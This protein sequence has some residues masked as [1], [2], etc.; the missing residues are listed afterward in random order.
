[1]AQLAINGASP[2]REAPYPAWTVT[3]EKDYER[4]SRTFD[5]RTWGPGGA[6]NRAFRAAFEAY[7]GSK[8]CLTVAN[9]TVSIEMILRALS[10]GRGDEV[11]LTSPELR[12]DAATEVY[13]GKKDW[14]AVNLLSSA[15]IPARPERVEG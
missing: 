10:I 8:H 9:G 14:Y 15:G 1:M 7:S 13:V 5:S 4:L 6:Q 12:A 2:L 3:T 11:I